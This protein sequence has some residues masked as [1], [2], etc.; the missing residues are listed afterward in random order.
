MASDWSGFVPQEAELLAAKEG[1]KGGSNL[2]YIDYS[3][4]K[5][6]EV[7]LL[8]DILRNTCRC[9]NLSF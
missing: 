5:P 9:F 4:L 7:C 8:P 6:G 2:Y 1:R 3:L